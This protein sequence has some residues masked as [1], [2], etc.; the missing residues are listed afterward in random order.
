MSNRIPLHHPRFR[1][2]QR[3][4]FLSKVVADC[5]SHQ[6]KLTHQGDRTKLDA[7][8]Q[9]GA[10]T[11]VSERDGILAHR[12]EIAALLDGDAARAEWFTHD[13][14][15]DPDF[16]TGRHVRT[17][18]HGEGCVFLS[19]D[20]RGCA[21]HRASLEGSWDMRGIKPHVC[22]LFPVSYD[23]DSIVMS[24]DYSDYSCAYDPEAPTVYQVARE[25]L[26]DIFGEDLVDVLDRAEQSVIV[27][28]LRVVG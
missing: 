5:M 26:A 27:G 19:H 21:I 3:E 18:V 17:V 25:A 1:W 6:C 22:R 9:Y 14:T 13:E 2:V 16:P 10:D 20:G 8:C 28:P 11:D 4:V 7:C 24:D 15:L 12:E 23:S